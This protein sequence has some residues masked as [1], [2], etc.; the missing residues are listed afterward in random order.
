MLSADN[1]FPSA[2]TAASSQTQA[3]ALAGTQAS[4]PT[5]P[6]PG[7]EL[8]LGHM[9]TIPIIQVPVPG[10][11]VTVVGGGLAGSE[12][13]LQIASMGYRVA[14]VEMRPLR[15][16]PAHHTDLLGELVCSNSLK[17]I[18]ANSAHGILKEDL[19]MLGCKLLEIARQHQVPAGQA[20]AVNRMDFARAVTAAVET[21][22]NITIIRGEVTSLPSPRPLTGGS[23]SDAAGD[24]SV[25]WEGVVV[26]A[27]GPLTSAPLAANIAQATNNPHGLWFYDAIAPIIDGST[28]NME[29]VF[30]ASRY[31]KGGADYLNCPLDRTQYQEF[32]Q[33]LMG[34]E[35]V[36]PHWFESTKAFQGCQPIESIAATGQ[37][38][39]R[40]GPMKPVG[41]ED[42]ETGRRPWAAIQLRR[43]DVAGNA[44][45]MVGFQTR[46]TYPEQK[47]LFQTIPGLENASFLR[48]GSIHRNT[49]INSPVLVQDD[50]SLVSN[51][52]QVWIA[53]QLT[54]VE[55]YVESIASG[56]LCALAVASRLRHEVPGSV[57]ISGSGSNRPGEFV[58]PPPSTALGAL[59]RH[60]RNGS[61]RQGYQPSAIHFGLMPIPSPPPPPP[62]APPL[63][64]RH[65]FSREERG[66]WHA[67]QSQRAIRE[68]RDRFVGTIRRP[69]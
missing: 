66:T 58:P 33:A 27:T 18:S 69:A 56:L 67:E 16:S 44:W 39:L 59:Y 4:T 30:T 35:K 11:H 14:L 57:N 1:F 2:L 46:L 34:A 7:P 22:A 41:L 15:S 53:G 55:G 29:R 19:T 63:R 13:A 40:F 6:E 10:F 48:F 21:D 62:D 49:F 68:W 52:G 20:L 64:R 37:D 50:L 3:D 17:S 32:H 28:I 54:G 60:T 8:G 65:S 47:R 31:D 43:E 9:A 45:N 12:C 38:S 5:Q 25:P 51:P 42:P 24:N 23:G 26:I 36:T 61:V